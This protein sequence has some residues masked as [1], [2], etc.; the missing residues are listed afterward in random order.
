[1]GKVRHGRRHTDNAAKQK[2]Y[3]NRRDGLIKDLTP[4]QREGYFP[5]Y[6]T[7]ETCPPISQNMLHVLK[8]R[9][10]THG[11]PLPIAGSAV[12]LKHGMSPANRSVYMENLEVCVRRAMGLLPSDTV[13]FYV[14]EEA[15][16]Q[17]SAPWY[18][19]Y[20]ESGIG[21]YDNF[22]CLPR[23]DRSWSV[24]QVVSSLDS[25][26]RLSS[27]CVVDWDSKQWESVGQIRTFTNKMVIFPTHHIHWGQVAKDGS[28]AVIAAEFTLNQDAQSRIMGLALT[29]Q[30]VL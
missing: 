26:F 21:H 16:I 11:S 25:C 30:Q 5:P 1:M 4:A 20:Q 15:N 28:R 13:T 17:R 2:A 19:E 24:S 14:D 6:F 29:S 9:L 3:R 23:A 7:T 18:V 27:R 8:T 12:Y 10:A 22:P